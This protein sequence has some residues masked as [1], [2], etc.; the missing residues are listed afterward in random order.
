MTRKVK[1]RS[2]RTRPK[3]RSKGRPDDLSAR[4]RFSAII[5][6]FTTQMGQTS[7]VA[8]A[9]K[10]RFKEQF[11]NE[12]WSRE[13]IYAELRAGIVSGYVEVR[14]LRSDL[15]TRLLERHGLKSAEV[16]TS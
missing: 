3:K 6:E 9:L 12:K 7:H 16:I 8:K 2:P 13:S 14:T 10:E 11:P 5:E 4:E 1:A 15:G